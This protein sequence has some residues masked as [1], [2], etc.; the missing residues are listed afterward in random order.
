[1]LPYKNKLEEISD[2]DIDMMVSLL[3]E[4][5]E[6]EVSMILSINYPLVIQTLYNYGIAL[7]SMSNPIPFY[8]VHLYDL[9]YT[10]DEIAYKLKM[11]RAEVIFY[12]LPSSY[13]QQMYSGFVR[14]LLAK[15]RKDYK[16]FSPRVQKFPYTKLTI[17][18]Y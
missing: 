1:M 2:I 12:V 15:V 10:I 13:H 4:Y 6:K 11:Q 7:H 18:G 14:H 3:K 16:M 5:N 9:G 8:A 17:E